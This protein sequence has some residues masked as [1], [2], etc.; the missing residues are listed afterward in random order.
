MQ[1]LTNKELVGFVQLQVGSLQVQV[2][3]RAESSSEEETPQPLATFEMEGDSCAIL[4]RGDA[5]SKQV[6][7]A[8]ADAA[9]QAVRHLSRK[10][11]N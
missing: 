10:L 3:I 6:E 8:M 11:L 5:S 2:P 1:S 9:R 7:R 4:V